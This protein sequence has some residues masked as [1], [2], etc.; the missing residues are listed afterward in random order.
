MKL[1][2]QEKLSLEEPINKYLPKPI[3]GDSILIKHILSHT[4]QGNV[5][6][7]FYYSSRFGF[8]T[9]VIEQST[10]KSFSEVIEKEILIPLKLKN[11]FLLKDSTQIARIAKPYT[12]DHG[13]ENGMVS[14]AAI[15]IQKVHSRIAE[16]EI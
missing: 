5:G 6:Q 16:I 1:T 4:S 12:L 3:L 9:N 13:I 11:T 14:A 10:G 8:L 2:E 7:K 15:G